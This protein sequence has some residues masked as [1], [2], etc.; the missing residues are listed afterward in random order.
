M[1]LKTVHLI[2]P[3]LL[4]ILTFL[5]EWLVLSISVTYTIF[6]INVFDLS[7]FLA[8]SRLFDEGTVSIRISDKSFFIFIAPEE[9]LSQYFK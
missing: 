8:S 6:Y 9:S 3:F 1:C 4:L 7:I 2:S 5:C